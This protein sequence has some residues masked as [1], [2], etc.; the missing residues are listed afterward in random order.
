MGT[1]QFAE[2]VTSAH[3]VGLLEGHNDRSANCADCH[4]SHTALVP[5]VRE[6]PNVCGKCH[7]LVRQAYFAGAHREQIAAA[8][9]EAGCIGCHENHRTEM[10]PF[11]EIALIC[12]NCHDPA[13]PQATAG[14]ELQQQILRAEGAGDRAR[15]A[16]D[17]LRTSGERTADEEIRLQTV[18]THLRELLV[19]AHSLD[20]VVVEDLSRRIAS[21]SGEIVERAESVEEHRWE[22]QLL[23]IPVW[24]LV[25][26]GILLALRKSR[27]LQQREPAGP[28]PT[29]KGED[30]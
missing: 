27:V 22:R 18:E 20:P 9:R 28:V 21:I 26:G 6:I 4:G 2:W 17:V 10:P 7:Q 25:L 12:Q 13:S 11:S 15:E 19:V 3:G 24:I 8:T 14:L 29:A 1:E 5:G 30:R 16:V 23:A